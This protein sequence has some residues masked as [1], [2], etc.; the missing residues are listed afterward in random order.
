MLKK[1]ATIGLIGAALLASGCGGSDDSANEEDTQA[2]TALVEELNRVT[3]EKD[4][5][6]F[7]DVM[8]PS[9]VEDT[10][11]SKERCVSETEKILKQAGEQPVLDVEDIQ[12][13]GDQAEVK[14]AGR[15]GTAIFVKEDGEWYVPFSTGET[16][17]S[18]A[19][20]EGSEG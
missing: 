8:Q 17:D 16:S 18:S 4:A 1:V 3:S 6:G 19:D 9:Q 5:A 14:F 11:H 13:D 10:F 2:L 15:A 20:T 7:C 12:V